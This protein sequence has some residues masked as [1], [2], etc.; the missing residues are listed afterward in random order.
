M[1]NSIKV[2]CNVNG[3]ND[4][5]YLTILAGSNS[6]TTDVIQLALQQMHI[7]EDPSFYDLQ[8]SFTTEVSNPGRILSKSEQPVS[9]YQKW[10][11]RKWR[12]EMMF[13][14]R[15]QSL[16]RTDLAMQRL[17]DNLSPDVEDHLTD[18]MCNLS[19]LSES[20][21]LATLRTRFVHNKIY[22]YVGS[23]LIAV[24]PYFFYPIYNPNYREVYQSG[25][26]GDHPPHIFAVAND[27]YHSMLS[28]KEDQAVIISGESGAG[29]TESTKFL[30]H[31]LMNLSAKFEEEKTLELITLGTGPVLEVSAGLWQR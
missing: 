18:D 24:N 28:D 30:L 21:M 23:I 6:S 16:N 10:A 26:L 27:A 19:E 31:H 3:S 22:T 11:E 14:L 13:R 12:G 9:L 2:H 8:E 5:G 4:D 1:A 25:K 15:K 7:Y 29:K 17:M 20:S